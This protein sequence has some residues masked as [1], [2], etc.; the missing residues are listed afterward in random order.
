M[1]AE[2]H[3]GRE[4]WAYHHV[5]FAA[6]Q[7]P[8]QNKL[9]YILCL[10]VPALTV[11][12]QEY[13]NVRK[14]VSVVLAEGIQPTQKKKLPRPWVPSTQPTWCVFYFILFPRCLS[15][16]WDESVAALKP[17]EYDAQFVNSLS[18]ET[19]TLLHSEKSVCFFSPLHCYYVRTSSLSWKIV[20]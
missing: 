5:H 15:V 2:A 13:G 17:K 9:L 14:A 19:F 10:L 20:A 11:E 12:V 8:L 18:Y 3:M 6:Y 16:Y 4:F 7:R 1:R